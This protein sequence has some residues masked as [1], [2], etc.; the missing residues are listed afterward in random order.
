MASVPGTAAGPLVWRTGPTGWWTVLLAA[1]ALVAYFAP[2]LQ[3]MVAT[4]QQVE[5]YS[6]G[7]FIPLISAFLVWQRSDE[8]RQHELRG[9]WWGVPVLLL[10]LALGVVGHSSAVRLLSQY[11]FLLGVVGLSLASIGTRGTRILA[12]PLALLVFMIPLPQFLLRELSQALQLLSS[13][14]GVALIRAAGIS[15]F[16]EGNVIDLGTYKLQVVDACSGLRY[17]FPLL[18]LGCLAA[19][20][21]R[22][23]W[24]QRALL[25]ASTVPLT[26]VINSARIGLIG[27]T[28]EHRGVAA[29]EGL[30]HDLEGGFMFLLCL[31]LLGLQ[32]VLLA[33]LGGRPWREAFVIE[34]PDRV[35]RGVGVGVR[36]IQAPGLA[37]LGLTLLAAA[38]AFAMPAREHE[39][40]PR[41]SYAE[42]PLELAGGWSGRTD[43]LQPDVIAVLAVTDYALVN[44]RRPGQPAVNFYSGYYASQSGGESNHSPR[45]CLPGGGW[46]ITELDQTELRP[47]AGAAALPVNRAVIQMG[48]QR[49]LVYYWFRQR[50]HQLTSEWRVK[51][52]IL[53]DGILHDRSDGAL[54]RLTTPVAP[55]EELSA[56][57]SR[58]TALAL[59][60]EPHLKRFIPD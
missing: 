26:I 14:L 50:G 21:F 34:V 24:W 54:V 46:A 3:F 17:L 60:V 58:L 15:V 25:V 20:F 18:V 32:M 45:T 7:W 37:A 27:I 28:V 29:A 13:Q 40:P 12:V 53:L 8:L 49:Q 5:E 59:A 41:T 22:A 43:R 35:P 42:F 44:Y 52:L 36:A 51:W 30:L 2:A 39:P 31:L 48:E 6:Y 57:D 47:G 9:S 1:G 10:G 55:D 4:W 38:L 16:L 56:A 11:G 23:P 19:Y 33:R